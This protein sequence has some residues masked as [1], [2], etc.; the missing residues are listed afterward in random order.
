MSINRSRRETIEEA[1]TGLE[2]NRRALPRRLLAIGAGLASVYLVIITGQQALQAYRAN[3]EV[4][5]VRREIVTLRA[6]NIELQNELVS[7]KLDE[8]IERTAREQLGLAR[9]G[10]HPVVLV[11]PSGTRDAPPPVAVPTA[12]AEPNWREWLHLFVDADPPRR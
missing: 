4:E 6:R 5:A 10:E 7:P 11:W 8:D 9:P 12:V 2:P 1:M 3:Q